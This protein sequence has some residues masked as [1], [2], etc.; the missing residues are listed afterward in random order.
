MSCCCGDAVPAG[1]LALGDTDGDADADGVTLT[2]ADGLT[3]ELGDTDGC[4]DDVLTTGAGVSG[5][6]PVNELPR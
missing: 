1:E 3:L 4:S 5:V 6:T 2:V